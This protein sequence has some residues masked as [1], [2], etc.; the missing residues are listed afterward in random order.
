MSGF[1]KRLKDNIVGAA[2]KILNKATSRAIPDI[3]QKISEESLR[4][5]KSTETYDSLINAGGGA[6]NDKNLFH[7]FGFRPEEAKQ[8]VDNFLEEASKNIIV[9]FRE[10]KP[11]TKSILGGGIQIY[12][13]KESLSEALTSSSSSFYSE[14]GDSIDWARWLL[15]EGNKFVISSHK[16]KAGSEQFSRSGD[17]IMIKSKSGGFRVPTEHQ[18]ISGD[19]WLTRSLKE[20]LQEVADRYSVIIK[21]AIVR[22]L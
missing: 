2:T 17:G 13:L 19:N 15:L 8:L 10:F 11:G 4:I 7:Q 20:S 1:L 14:N 22:R 18:G 6:G 9:E 12:I 16:F 3:S 21:Q 5:W